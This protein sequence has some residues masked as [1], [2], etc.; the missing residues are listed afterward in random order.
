METFLM[1]WNPENWPWNDI[2]DCIKKIEENGF[3]S[4]RWSLSR[5]IYKVV[6]GSRIFIVRLGQHP[7][8]II[9]SARVTSDKPYEDDHWLYEGKKAWYVKIDY[10]T[11]T[12]EPLLTINFLNSNSP[13]NRFRRGFKSWTPRGSGVRI[14]PDIAKALESEWEKLTSKK[15]SWQ[16]LPEEIDEDV[17]Y[18]EG[19]KRKVTVNA[20]ERS[21]PA[22][23]AC[24]QHYGYKCIVCG[25]SFEEI[26]GEIGKNHIEVHHL[27]ELSKAGPNY[28]IN[29][30]QD[31]R[32]VCPNCHSVIHLSKPHPF[33]IEEVE[34]MIHRSK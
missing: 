21:R 27:V 20:Y 31:L 12:T 2:E 30:I 11:L 4:G 15:P 16:P 28:K 24:L 17:S 22:R 18:P 33:T 3:Y 1:T 6:K 23:Q 29:H 13:F 7:K 25:F 32:P 19:A 26:Y 10:D 8:G 14:P 34:K 5:N 9:G